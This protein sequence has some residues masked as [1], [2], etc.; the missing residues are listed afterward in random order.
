MAAFASYVLDHRLM[1][2]QEFT[3]EQRCTI[4]QV[5][6]ARDASAVKLVCMMPMDGK[7]ANEF[8]RLCRKIYEDH[9]LDYTVGRKT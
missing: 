1:R 6:S 3:E 4:P 5:A 8:Q 7:I 9:G 2:S